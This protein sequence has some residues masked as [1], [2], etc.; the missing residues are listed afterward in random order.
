MSREFTKEEVRAEFLRNAKNI[1]NYWATLEGKTAE[2]RCQ[3][4][5]FS[6]LVMLDGG[7][8]NSPG[9]A[10]LPAPHES[11]KQYYIDNKQNYY[12]EVPA[13]AVKLDIAGTLHEEYARMTR[14]NK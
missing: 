7:N 1:A 11:D 10:V 6:M 5:L 2:E 4:T 13:D 3:G 14:D 9:F 12:S 8:G